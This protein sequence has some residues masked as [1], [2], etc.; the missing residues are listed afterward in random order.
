LYYPIGLDLGG[1]TPE[2]VAMAM[3]AEMTAVLNG[4]EG[5]MLKLRNASIHDLPSTRVHH[6]DATELSVQPVPLSSTEIV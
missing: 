3:L 5:G 1:D 6:Q 4:R 2:S